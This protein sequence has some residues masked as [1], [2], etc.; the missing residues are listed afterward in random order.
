MKKNRF[1]PKKLFKSFRFA[2]NGIV[3]LFCTEQNARIHRV[4]CILVI[5]AGFLLRI[6]RLEWCIVVLC[7]GM[8]LSAEAFNTAIEKLVDHHFPEKNETARSVKDL[9]A[10]AVLLLA[11]AAVVCG[12]LVFLPRLWTLFSNNKLH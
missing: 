2:F 6:S 9:A 4:I 5:A 7:M 12:L 11:I 3:E 10:G 8:V 1:H